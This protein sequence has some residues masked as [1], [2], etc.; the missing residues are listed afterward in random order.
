MADTIPIGET[1][2]QGYNL[3]KAEV[4]YRTKLDPT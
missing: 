4:S 2:T 1:P 3:L